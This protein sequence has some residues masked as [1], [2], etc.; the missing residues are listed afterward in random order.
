MRSLGNRIVGTGS[1]RISPA[2]YMNSVRLLP[3]LAR[4]VVDWVHVPSLAVFMC[5][6]YVVGD[7]RGDICFCRMMIVDWGGQ[8]PG[9]EL[10]FLES[11]VSFDAYVLFYDVA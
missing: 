9:G 11:L 10:G 3:I 2:C 4:G 8:L 7:R 1:P 6:I 5:C